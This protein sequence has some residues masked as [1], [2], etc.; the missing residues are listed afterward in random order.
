M[1]EY[2]DDSPKPYSA[3]QLAD[4]ANSLGLGRNIE[5]EAVRRVVG[6]AR[7]LVSQKADK[8]PD[9]IKRQAVAA[10]EAAKHET[11]LIRIYE[12]FPELG[13]APAAARRAAFQIYFHKEH[14]GR[15]GRKPPDHVITALIQLYSVWHD[16]DSKRDFGKENFIHAALGPFGYDTENRAFDNHRKQALAIFNRKN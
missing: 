2:P 10:E 8:P 14:R 15:A 6:I 1:T 4:I 11:A 13:S 9:F 16:V 3:E 5:N 12:K 7:T